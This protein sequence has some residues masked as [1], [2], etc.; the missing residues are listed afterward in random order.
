MKA[1]IS[2]ILLFS[3]ML[4]CV[5]CS[6]KNNNAEKST[7]DE[8]NS[9]I[10]S[11]DQVTE[12]TTT[13]EK[14]TEK[15]NDSPDN[16]TN[17]GDQENGTKHYEFELGMVNFD[18]FFTY[19]IENSINQSGQI[20][21]NSLHKISGVL[22]YAYYENVVV[23]FEVKCTDKYGYTF[24]TNELKVPLNASGGI[25]L[26]SYGDIVNNGINCEEH[27]SRVLTIKAISGKVIFNM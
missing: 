9:S 6:K 10:V 14:P 11:T 4:A 8:L 20:V 26:L 17:A 13:T 16:N 12:T 27:T 3:I 19:S 24:H 5:S 15:P 18:R 2:T 25:D 22:S 7:Q 1:I 21:K 23:T